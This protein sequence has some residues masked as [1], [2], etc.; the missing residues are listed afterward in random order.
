MK[1]GIDNLANLGKKAV[2]SSGETI[3]R[4]GEVAARTAEQ[5][6]D[7]ARRAADQ[8]LKAAEQVGEKVKEYGDDFAALVRKHPI[9]ALLIGFGVGYLC[10]RACR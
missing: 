2:E 6:Q 9:Q 8:G 4:V 3:N 7:R 10:S 1:T 5:V